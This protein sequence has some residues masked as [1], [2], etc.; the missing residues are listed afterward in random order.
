MTH[1]QE[2]ASERE[3][4]RPGAKKASFILRELFY[5]CRDSFTM[6]LVV[7]SSIYKIHILFTSKKD[8]VVY[9]EHEA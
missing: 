5:K 6:N 8:I 1:K 9:C 3:I 7:A 2:K 4:P